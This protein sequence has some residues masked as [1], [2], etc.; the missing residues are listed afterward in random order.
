[1]RKLLDFLKTKD[2][3]GPKSK[4]KQL[5]NIV[6]FII[7]LII[8]VLIINNIMK[9]D[10]KEAKDNKADTSKVLA[11]T[12]NTSS[13]E[14]LEERLA[15]IL[16]SMAGV[17]K[18]KVLIKYSETSSIVPIYNE[19]TSES[20]T[21]ETDSDGGNKNTVQTDVKKEIV[22]SDENG[23]SQIITK[24]VDMPVIEGAIITAQGASNSNIKASIV[25]AVEAITGLATHKIQVF[26]MNN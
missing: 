18:V 26:E 1:M 24:K 8:T 3:K 11:S 2:N 22:Y 25:S 16:E 23:N 5:E 9:S 12:E 6:V 17:G 13:E 14:N 21:E 19:T 20:K 7:I 4:Q 15:D 10:K